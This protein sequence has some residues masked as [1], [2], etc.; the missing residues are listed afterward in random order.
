VKI[1][2]HTSCGAKY[3]K[4]G[5]HSVH[6]R[7]KCFTRCELGFTKTKICRLNRRR[8]SNGQCR[9]SIFAVDSLGLGRS[10]LSHLKSPGADLLA[11]HHPLLPSAFKFAMINRTPKWLSLLLIWFHWGNVCSHCH[12]STSIF[13]PR[14]FPA[15]QPAPSAAN[16]RSELP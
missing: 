4:C 1:P 13:T 8:R 6:L 9:M 2:H 3:S 16:L 12:V 7:E 11:C 5:C 14:R 10:D 15:T